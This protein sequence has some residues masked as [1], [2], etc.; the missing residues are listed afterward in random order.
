MNEAANS[1]SPE[2]LTESEI[3]FLIR[4]RDQEQSR[5]HALPWFILA[6]FFLWLGWDAPFAL[7]R[8]RDLPYK[9]TK[10][11]SYEGIRAIHTWFIGF[12]WLLFAIHSTF[13]D[14]KRRLLVK[15]AS[16]V[17]IPNDCKA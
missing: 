14:R 11:L 2:M 8:F 16:K 9:D 12:G 7:E 13:M 3:K 5:F 1:H 10:D 4:L 15:L 17:G 6:A